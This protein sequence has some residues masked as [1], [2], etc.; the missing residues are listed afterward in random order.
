MTFRAKLKKTFSK[1]SS[2]SGEST[3]SGDN[4]YAVRTDIEYY[5]PNEIPKSKYRGKVDKA[6]KEKLESFTF[7]DAFA[8]VRRKSSQA[9]SGTFSPG[10]T[11]SQSRRASWISRP[12]SRG[13]A[14][15]SEQDNRSVRRK[16]VAAAGIPSAEPVTENED[17]DAEVVN[18][19]STS[20]AP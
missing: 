11:K 13:S 18:G 4:N 9:L 14:T 7:A 17:E 1:K 6:H 2:G 20:H 10:G 15:G 12:K 8:T 19:K 5:K 16:S 3:P